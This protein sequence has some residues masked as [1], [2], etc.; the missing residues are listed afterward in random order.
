MSPVER[1]HSSGRL[2]PF[3][4]FLTVNPY[5]YSN[6]IQ[7][8]ERVKY[9]K[10]NIKDMKMRGWKNERQKPSNTEIDGQDN[11][12]HFTVARHSYLDM[13]KNKMTIF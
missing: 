4:W 7:Y 11:W 12:E 2:T 8:K 13:W 6:K 5:V 9:L 10:T 1:S 3:T